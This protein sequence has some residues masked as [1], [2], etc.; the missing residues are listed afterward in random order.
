[1]LTGTS[2]TIDRQI[3]AVV[4]IVAAQKILV[5]FALAG[6]LGHDQAGHGFQHFARPRHRTRVELFAGDGHL[7]RHAG[8]A[9]R[10]RSRYSARRTPTGLAAG[11]QRWTQRRVAPPTAACAMRVSAV[12]AVLPRAAAVAPSPAAAPAFPAGDWAR[13]GPAERRRPAPQVPTH[14]T[15][16]TLQPPH[17]DKPQ[18][19]RKPIA[20]PRSKHCIDDRLSN[21]GKRYVCTSMMSI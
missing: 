17:F 12:D 8:R 11:A 14:A 13:A 16:A 15:A 4:E 5:G 9:G 21:A 2:S 7:A 6:V 19:V 18:R 10:T 3:G 1:M 20:A